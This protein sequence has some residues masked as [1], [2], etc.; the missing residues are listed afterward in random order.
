MDMVGI[1]ADFE[2]MTF[3][4]VAY[5][6]EVG[7]QL[8]FDRR[9]N[10]MLPVLGTEDDVDVILCEGLSHRCC[11]TPFQGYDDGLGSSHD[12]L[13]PSVMKGALSGLFTNFPS[14]AFFKIL[15]LKASTCNK[16]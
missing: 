6:S 13:R 2:D 15:C 12:G 7:V 11:I 9:V 16:L 8:F 4:P 14:N 3:Q 10:E 1:A 5:T